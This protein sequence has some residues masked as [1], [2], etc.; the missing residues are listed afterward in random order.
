MTQQVRE[1]TRNTLLEL[2]ALKDHSV[3]HSTDK[4]CTLMQEKSGLGMTPELTAL[5]AGLTDLLPWELRKLVG[6]YPVRPAIVKM[7]EGLAQKNG[8]PA[9]LAQ[10]SL[11]TWAESVGLTVEAV[12]PAPAGSTAHAPAG[13]PRNPGVSAGSAMP[14]S[15]S[16]SAPA[17]AS[18]AP[19]AQ[20]APTT[21]SPPQTARPSAPASVASA[22][23]ATTATSGTPV[24]P[25]NFPE[26]TTRLGI[27]YGIDEFQ[28]VHVFRAWGKAPGATEQAGLA[29]VLVKRESPVSKAFSG[30]VPAVSRVRSG[31]VPVTMK[32]SAS[33]AGRGAKTAS[34]ASVAASPGAT[35][36]AVPGAAPTAGT[37]GGVVTAK[38][39][40]PPPRKPGLTTIIVSSYGPVA[41]QFYKQA[42]EMLT[43]AV[44]RPNIQEVVKV[45]VQAAKLGHLSAEYRIGEIYLRGLHVKEDHEVAFKWFESAAKKGYGDAQVQLGTMY[46]CGMGVPANPG[47]AKKWYD[48]A[49][50]QGNEE[51]RALLKQ[52]G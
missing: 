25:T 17:S 20:A 40:A 24:A 16:T 42:M 39:V 41:D 11:L 46:Q 6:T 4:F 31:P 34:S 14:A 37:P 22:T 23:V 8:F 38:R 47:E 5:K 32:K 50:G 44:G 45:F 12:G 19:V 15:T 33:G 43:P 36:G 27:L 29:A 13:A 1:K 2:V 30:V 3:F 28:A 7:A 26:P 35:K 10:W 49:A 48:S 21:A 51:A 52:V 18:K 9:E